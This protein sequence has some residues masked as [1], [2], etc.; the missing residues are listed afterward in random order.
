MRSPASLDKAYG[1][2]FMVSASI[3]SDPRPPNNYE[4]KFHE[5]MCRYLSSHERLTKTS[6]L[7]TLT[8]STSIFLTWILLGVYSPFLWVHLFICLYMIL[9][10]WS[11]AHFCL[12]WSVGFHPSFHPHSGKTQR[13]PTSPVSRYSWLQ[14]SPCL[15]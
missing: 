9:Y 2:C 14:Q 13:F 11:S 15:F 12:G 8:L 1:A 4:E 6:I 3:L 5:T 7:L 10:K